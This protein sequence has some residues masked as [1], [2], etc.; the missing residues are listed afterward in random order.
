MA[1]DAETRAKLAALRTGSVAGTI[2]L[3]EYREAIRLMRGPRA[4]AQIASAPKVKVKK[5]RS[6]K[7]R[8][9]PAEPI[10]STGEKTNGNP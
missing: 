7:A 8:V 9:P 10:P 4:A 5:P 3:D 6:P 2:T 1:Q